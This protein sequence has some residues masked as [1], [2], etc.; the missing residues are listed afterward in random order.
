[1]AEKTTATSKKS[2]GRPKTAFVSKKPKIKQSGPWRPKKVQEILDIPETKPQFANKRLT[3]ND[4]KK[5]DA[6]I[7]IMFVLSLVLFTASLFFSQKKETINDEQISEQPIENETAP[8][9]EETTGE[10]VT[11]EDTETEITETQNTLSIPNLLLSSFYES[12]NNGTIDQIYPN[13]TTSLKASK[14]FK[15]YFSKT[16][17]QRF[18]KN[19]SSAWVE[20]SDIQSDNKENPTL[21]YTISYALKD[22]KAFEETRSMQI[23]NKEVP[24]IAKMMC[25]NTGCS[26]FPFFNPGKYTIH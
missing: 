1:M 9:T 23:I 6:V 18:L 14:L 10:A 26:T 8:I 22:G 13:I 25:I 11:T 3:A 4:S 19:L 17:T 12:F 7:L 16:R 21:T 24:Q 2:R 15:V 5:K 20:I